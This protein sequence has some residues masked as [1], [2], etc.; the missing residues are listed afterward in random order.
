M[1]D[2]RAKN[3]NTILRF[4]S[5]KGPERKA[6]RQPLF[7][8][9]GCKQMHMRI[10]GKDILQNQPA[11]DWL[12]ESTAMVPEW[13]FYENKIFQTED[14]ERFLVKSIGRGNSTFHENPDLCVYINYYINEFQMRD[15]KILVF[16]E[17]VFPCARQHF[18]L[19]PGLHYRY[20]GDLNM[21][22]EAVREENRETV[23]QFLSCSAES[24][25]LVWPKLFSEDAICDVEIQTDWES[26]AKTI[27]A[28][29]WQT[30]T[31]WSAKRDCSDFVTFWGEDPNR[32]LAKVTRRDAP[33]LM[34]F[35]VEHGRIT[36]I[37]EAINP[38]D[39]LSES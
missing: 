29:A 39:T 8:P 35:W 36:R 10:Q 16:R 21:T 22:L 19:G 4:L 7:S 17:T 24:R 20:K 31:E 25:E 23:K 28:Q 32:I 14:P 27:P 37:S 18:L 2:I 12:E 11:L 34:E 9:E 26:E 30:E 3:L 1:S 5:C 13:G 15:G 38:C 33:Y 6:S